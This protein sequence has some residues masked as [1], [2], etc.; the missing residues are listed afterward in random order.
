[1]KSLAVV[2]PAP[3]QVDLVELDVPDPANGEFTIQT[4]VTLM[5]MGTELTCYRADSEPGSHWHRWIQHP[6]YPGYSCVG[7]IVRV[8]A[9]VTGFHEGDRVF[10]AMSHRQFVRISPS[11]TSS[12]STASWKLPILT[13]SNPGSSSRFTAPRKP[14][15]RWG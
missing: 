6:F 15:L 13:I 1:M 10:C 11:T 12:D 2:F 9:H 4:L 5:S 7:R 14:R 3:R 8:G